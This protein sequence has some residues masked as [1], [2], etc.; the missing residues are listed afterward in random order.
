M[1]IHNSPAYDRGRADHETR[2]AGL[3]NCPPLDLDTYDESQFS[4]PWMYRRGW[5]SIPDAEPHSCPRCCD[6]RPVTSPSGPAADEA[7]SVTY[8]GYDSWA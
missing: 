2:N 3:A 1:G 7:Q 4:G 8:G 6:R 5:S